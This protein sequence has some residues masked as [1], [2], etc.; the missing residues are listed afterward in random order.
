MFEHTAAVR[1]LLVGQPALVVS[2]VE[3]E[4]ALGPRGAARS[5]P[6]HPGFEALETER[7]T[8][9]VCTAAHG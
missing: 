9:A 7:P 1:E 6:F 3:R 5:R 4:L 8:V 2:A